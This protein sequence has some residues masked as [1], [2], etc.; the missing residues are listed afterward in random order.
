MARSWQELRDR[1]R[2][3]QVERIEAAMNELDVELTVWEMC[4]DAGVHWRWGWQQL[5]WGEPVNMAELRMRRPVGRLPK[6]G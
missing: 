3:D 5:G 2:P 1:L 4:H 6:A